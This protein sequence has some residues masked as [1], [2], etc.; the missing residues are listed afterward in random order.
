MLFC[1]IKIGLLHG[2][3]HSSGPTF[4]DSDLACR[5]VAPCNDDCYS[6]YDPTVVV[7][8]DKPNVLFGDNKIPSNHRPP[9]RGAKTAIGW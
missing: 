2:T 6:V 1:A 9:C 5:S 8:P 7:D 4:G 3:S